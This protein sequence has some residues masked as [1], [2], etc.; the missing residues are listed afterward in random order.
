MTRTVTTAMPKPESAKE[1]EA[2]LLLLMMM[3]M[4]MMR[5]RRRRRRRKVY[6]GANAVNDM[7]RRVTV[8]R[9]TSK[10]P[11]LSPYRRSTIK[12]LLQYQ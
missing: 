9:S 7:R 3:M 11:N 8:Q 1:L 10:Q 4:M 2:R 12:Q 6:S 5:R